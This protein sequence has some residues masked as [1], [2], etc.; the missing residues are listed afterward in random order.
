MGNFDKLSN[1]DWSKNIIHSYFR[2]R[3]SIWYWFDLAIQGVCLKWSR[4][5]S[6]QWKSWCE[7]WWS[8]YQDEYSNNS[9]SKSRFY[10]NLMD[11]NYCWRRYWKRQCYL[12]QCLLGLGIRWCRCKLVYTDQ[13]SY[14]HNTYNFP[15]AYFGNWKCFWNKL[16][17]NIQGLCLKWSRGRSLLKSYSS[18]R[19]SSYKYE[20]SELSISRSRLYLNLMVWYISRNRHRKRPCYLL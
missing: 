3:E 6:M 20:F 13:I 15:H 17:S 10:W 8:S 16:K 11:C 12:L 14:F 1:F 18:G 2:C 19:L 9:I 5:W 7:R 4:S